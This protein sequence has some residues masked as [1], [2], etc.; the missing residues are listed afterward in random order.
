MTKLANWF[1]Q[2]GALCGLPVE[3]D[4]ALLLSNGRKLQSVVRVS[5]VG[6]EH[7]MLIFTDH[8]AIGGNAAELLSLG[9]G[10]SIMSEP[11]FDEKFDLELFEE[12]FTDW[13]W[14]C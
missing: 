14:S 4:F 8:E 12:V 1:A 7:G 2:A 13:G 5:S 6:A 10:Y 9:Y 3:V 11:R